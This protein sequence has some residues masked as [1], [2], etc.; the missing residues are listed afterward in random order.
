[1]P[2]AIIGA[3]P[4]GLA[5]AAHLIERGIDVVLLEAGPSAGAAVAEWGHIK[6]FST[7][8]YNIDAAAARLLAAHGWE[9]PHPK[10]LPT[11]TDLVEQY[12]APLAGTEPIA[13]S[14]R[15][16]HR[17]TAVSRLGLD[18]TRTLG[19]ADAPFLIV[20]ETA[21]GVVHLTARAVIDA[22][23][24]WAQPNPVGAS[25]LEVPGEQEARAAGVVTSALPDVLGAERDRFAGQ[26]TL[27]IGGGHSAANTLLALGRLVDQV[28]GTRVTWGLRAPSPARVYGGGD[29]DGLPE[30]GALGTRLKNM[31][32]SGRIELRTQF[33][34]ASVHPHTSGLTVHAHTPHGVEEFDVAALVPATGFRP[35]LGLLR[36]LQLELDPV[37]EAPR[38][39]GPLI[40]PQFHSCG[41]V[42]A[43]GA[44]LLA[45][46]EP[47]FFIV[48]MK[49]YGR[50]PTFLMATGYEQVRS[51]AAHL[52]GDQPAAEHVELEL[53]ATGVCSTNA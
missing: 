26:H 25:G 3:G 53:P 30:R 44:T 5:A 14:L 32:E 16:G 48:G 40:D 1:M 49:S 13:A 52:A 6:T 42:P 2:V 21:D 20:S 22:S 35:N 41:T 24:T 28:P 31:V 38:E 10:R 8:R 19:R 17:V 18:T 36:E 29:A 50:A 45:H 46:P 12:L 51:I 27:V 33:T 9:P 39:L 23:G 4:V 34:V 43:H 11:G 47:N 15:T 7:W 37:M